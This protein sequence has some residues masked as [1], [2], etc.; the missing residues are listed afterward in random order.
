VAD[1]DPPVPW[2]NGPTS[3]TGGKG[4]VAT[5]RGGSDTLS[6][7][8]AGVLRSYASLCASNVTTWGSELEAVGGIIMGKTLAEVEGRVGV[9]K[10]GSGFVGVMADKAGVGK[11]GAPG[12]AE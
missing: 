3:W 6:G 12:A 1:P 5:A 9:G 7:G 2:D 8:L 11:D 4:S 10:S